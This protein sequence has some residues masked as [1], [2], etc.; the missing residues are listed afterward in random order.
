MRWVV[1]VTNIVSFAHGGLT[2]LTDQNNGMAAVA[3][4]S[5]SRAYKHNHS[6][7]PY[8]HNVNCVSARYVQ[9]YTHA[10]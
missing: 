9:T 1:N 2:S 7:I 10:M 6:S 5:Q 8:A 3:A 4:T